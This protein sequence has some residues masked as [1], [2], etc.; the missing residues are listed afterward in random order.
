MHIPDSFIPIGQ[1]LVYW[2]IALVFVA[3]S[4]RWAR[5]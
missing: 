1:G 3:L 5:T 2:A 4:L